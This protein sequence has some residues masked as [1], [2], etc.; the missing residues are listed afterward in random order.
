[1]NN[2]DEYPV[3]LRFAKKTGQVDHR[4][5]CN[6]ATRDCTS[7][8]VNTTVTVNNTL[9]NAMSTLG[10]SSTTVYLQHLEFS[11]PLNVVDDTTVPFEGKVTVAGTESP[12]SSGTFCPIIDAKVC[13]KDHG[14]RNKVEILEG[15]C[16]KTGLDGSFSLPA[17]L[18]TR[19]SPY[20]E[21]HNHTFR[22]LNPAHDVLFDTGIEIRA[23]VGYTGYNL[24]DVAKA[25]LTLEVG[26]HIK[27]SDWL[28]VYLLLL[29]DI[30]N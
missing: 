18:G 13:L 8:I 11:S 29:S 25:N 23:N 10:S 2:D 14:V 15:V 17:V 26:F 28:Y 3:E 19:V 6:E 1:L 21:Y 12:L 9:I 30:F 22:A 27:S 5:L 4:F 16:V 24:E 20:V 7:R